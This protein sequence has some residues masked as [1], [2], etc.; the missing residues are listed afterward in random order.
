MSN[1][2][3]DVFNRLQKLE[4]K[5]NVMNDNML[6]ALKHIEEEIKIFY[7]EL[8]RD[9]NVVVHSSVIISD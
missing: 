6:V 5:I 7:N 3:K 9:K 2:D 8:K 1:V 4:D